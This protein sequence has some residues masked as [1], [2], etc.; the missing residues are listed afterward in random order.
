MEETQKTEK[1]KLLDLLMQGDEGAIATV[2][3]LVKNNNLRQ[4][5]LPLVLAAIKVAIEATEGKTSETL[6]ALCAL[7]CS[8]ISVEQV[9][10]VKTGLLEKLGAPENEPK[11]SIGILANAAAILIDNKRIRNGNIETIAQAIAD[12]IAKMRTEPNKVDSLM[13]LRQSVLRGLPGNEEGDL[14]SI[15]GAMFNLAV[16]PTKSKESWFNI[17]IQARLKRLERGDPNLGRLV[18]PEL[19]E[20]MRNTLAPLSDGDAALPLPVSMRTA[21]RKKVSTMEIV[22]RIGRKI[23]DR[24]S[25]GKVPAN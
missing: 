22:S 11:E 14:G 9:A 13:H 23:A 7:T 21:P 4:D 2:S 18:T 20:R 5:Q 16:R 1:P 12:G 6:I 25:P 24:P 15:Y 8:K 10:A 17:I 19:A 3:E